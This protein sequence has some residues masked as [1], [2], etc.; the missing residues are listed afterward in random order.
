MLFTFRQILGFNHVQRRASDRASGYQFYERLTSAL[1][2][3]TVVALPL[4]LE[5]KST[6][7]LQ[8][9]KTLRIDKQ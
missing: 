6:S 4:I 1:I 5:G 9:F 2:S 7:V 8:I 3:K